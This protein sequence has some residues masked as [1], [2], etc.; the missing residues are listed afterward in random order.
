MDIKGIGTHL[1]DMV[2]KYKYAAIVLLVGIALLLLPGKRSETAQLK[3]EPTIT[4]NAM[5]SEALHE[6]LQSI[7]GA[8]K[9]KV[10]LS[11]ASGEKTV[12]QTDTD[13]SVTS[14]SSSTRT[15]SVIVTDSQRVENGLIQQVNPPVY[16][17]AVV[18]CQG[19]DSASVRYA[20][21]QAV[22]KITGLGTD[23]ICVVKMK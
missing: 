3:E 10:L 1:K 22:S 15:E 6:I 23:S 14:D 18:V 20:I 19:A 7:E 16:R 2:S 9:V 13:T 11:V 21:I 8:G 4:Q 5:D 17:G 12:Y